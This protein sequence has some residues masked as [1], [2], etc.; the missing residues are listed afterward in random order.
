LRKNGE[1][2]KAMLYLYGIEKTSGLRKQDILNS[3]GEDISGKVNEA[4]EYRAKNIFMAHEEGHLLAEESFSLMTWKKIIKLCQKEARAEEFVRNVLDV[5]A[6][7]ME[8]GGIKG[9]FPSI[10][11]LEEPIISGLLG[12]EVADLYFLGS[13]P[14]SILERDV[15]TGVCDYL[16]TNDRG[17][18]RDSVK[19]ILE[20]GIQI[21]DEINK[22]NEEG[23]LTVKT[24][25]KLRERAEREYR[26]ELPEIENSM[27][28]IQNTI[29]DRI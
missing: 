3:P 13:K 15:V 4:A 11:S 20:R 27:I 1:N 21:K 22:L 18:I 26:A 16:H 19:N 24:M 10:I 8:A 6:D 2:S 25:L 23:R 28:E 17:A 29:K 12:I 14:R 5:P 9:R 7:C